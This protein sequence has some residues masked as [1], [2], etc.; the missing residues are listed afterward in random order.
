M[1]NK[2]GKIQKNAQQFELDNFYKNMT[3]EQYKEGIRVAVKNS[4][5]KDA[6]GI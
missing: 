6:S 3:P 4:N 1:S 5:G 2:L